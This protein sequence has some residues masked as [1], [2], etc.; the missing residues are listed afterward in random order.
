MEVFLA[1]TP[2][3]SGNCKAFLETFLVESV[4]TRPRTFSL[5]LLE[6]LGEAASAGRRLGK[7]GIKGPE[8]SLMNLRSRRDD[9]IGGLEPFVG[10][11]LCGEVGNLAS[12]IDKLIDQEIEGA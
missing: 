11:E 1:L 9:G 12:D 8:L 3:Y 7:L 5:A 10:S 2:I 6:P 4:A